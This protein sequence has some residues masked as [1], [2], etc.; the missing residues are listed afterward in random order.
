M[1]WRYFSLLSIYTLTL[2]P[3]FSLL[4]SHSL[5]LQPKLSLTNKFQ[6]HSSN[7]YLPDQFLQDGVNNR[8]DEY[9]GSVANRARFVLELTD[10]ISGSIGAHRV[11]IRF[12]PWSTFQSMSDS[13]PVSLFSRIFSLPLPFSPFLPLTLTPLLH[14]LFTLHSSLFSLHAL[15]FTLHSHS[16]SF[17]IHHVILLSFIIHHPSSVIRRPSS[18]VRRPSSVVRRSSFVIR[19]SSFVVRILPSKHEINFYTNIFEK[20]RY[21]ANNTRTPPI[22]CIC[23]FH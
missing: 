15:R 4:T 1:V 9:G 16:T 14:S 12:S 13:D 10:A 23:S 2:T 19:H 21:L 20:I 11:G 17:F 5:S 7:G 3:H 18:V 8:V 6:I 22:I